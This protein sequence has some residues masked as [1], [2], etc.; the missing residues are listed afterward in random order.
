MDAQ[1]KLDCCQALQSNALALLAS[2]DV[3]SNNFGV[4][5]II[6]RRFDLHNICIS[7]IFQA[8]KL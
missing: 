6:D 4:S 3:T 1:K 2:P 7:T 8:T 5:K